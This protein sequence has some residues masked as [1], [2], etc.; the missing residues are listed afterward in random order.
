MWTL[1]PPFYWAVISTSAVFP[2]ADIELGNG[3]TFVLDEL[4][5]S[6]AQAW[7]EFLSR[8]QVNS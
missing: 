7:H 5:Q 1:R 4:S 6:R 8:Y 2:C 3:M